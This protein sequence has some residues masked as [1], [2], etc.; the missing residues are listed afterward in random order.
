M[1]YNPG[2]EITTIIKAYQRSIG[3]SK[4]PSVY[5][6]SKVVCIRY[7]KGVLKPLEPVIMVYGKGFYQLALSM[8][9]ES[10]GSVGK[11]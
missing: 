10:K 2:H 7:E 11:F 9:F 8:S 3:S 6:W 1:A 5:L 4:T